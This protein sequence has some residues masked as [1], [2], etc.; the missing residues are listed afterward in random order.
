MECVAR[1]GLPPRCHIAVPYHVREGDARVPLHERHRDVRQ[2][3]VLHR[4]VGT[5]IGAFEFDTDR[6]VVATTPTSMARDTGMPRAQIER[7]ELRD[8]SAAIDQEVGGNGKARKI[9]Q[10][11]ISR[12]VEAV[13]EQLLDMRATELSG[14]K[15]DAMD[16]QQFDIATGGTLVAVGRA[17]AARTLEPMGHVDFHRSMLARP[18][19][20]GNMR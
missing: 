6:K 17:H 5:R 14:R 3:L 2:R 8:L 16:D 20:P 1:V 11:G 13:L 9:A 12:T 19:R 10:S 18:W 15:A 4:L 7:H